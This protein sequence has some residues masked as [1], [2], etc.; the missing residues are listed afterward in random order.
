MQ[1]KTKIVNILNDGIGYLELVDIMPA[2]SSADLAIV[3]SA[4]ASYNSSST[5]TEK[6]YKLI[7]RLLEDKHTSPFEQ[8]VFKFFLKAPLIVWWQQIRHRTGSYSLSSG[9]YT[10][11]SDDEYY[12]PSKWRLQAKHNKQASE[13]YI[14][15][16]TGFHLTNDLIDHIRTSVRLYNKALNAGVARE[17]ARFY[18]PAFLCYHTG[19]FKMDLHNLLHYLSLRTANDAQWEIRQYALGIEKI[20]SEYCPITFSYWKELQEKQ[21]Q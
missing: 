3:D 10:E 1:E 5:G 2:N 7:K 15:S 12:I 6:D 18:L 21:K 19:I 13:G 11:Y 14:D 9:R 4:R 8:V 20:V 16:L 17:Q